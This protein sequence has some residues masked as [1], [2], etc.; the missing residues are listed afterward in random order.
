MVTIV[1]SAA[2]AIAVTLGSFAFCVD[3]IST[4]VY[5]TV[6]KCAWR[7]ARVMPISCVVLQKSALQKP[8]GCGGAHE[9]HQAPHHNLRQ[10]A[11]KSVWTVCVSLSFYQCAG[12]F[13]VWRMMRG[14]IDVLIAY[15]MCS[16]CVH[17]YFF[18]LPG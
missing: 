12:V 2:V 1:L 13:C 17:A 15:D 10:S 16:T 8:D 9:A 4:L 7:C 3:V 18:V 6:W 14:C 11:S 5:A